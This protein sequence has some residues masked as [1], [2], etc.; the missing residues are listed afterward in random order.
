MRVGYVQFA[1]VF[2]QKEANLKRVAAFLDSAKV[3]LIVLPE[4]FATGYIFESKQEL[5]R[6]AEEET[7]A[8]FTFLRGLSLKSG[9]AIVAGIAERYGPDCFNSCF[10]FADGE[11]TAR[12][13][14]VHLFDWEKEMFTPGRSISEICDLG[15]V[16]LGFMVCFDWIFPEVARTIALKG[17]QVLCHPA[18]LVLP[19]CPQAMITRC[20]ENRMF[21]ITA[22]RV[23]TEVRVGR[24]LTFIGTSQ[25]VGP[26][27]RVLIRAGQ[28]E[29]GI[30]VIDIDPSRAKDKMV[31]PRNHVITDRKPSLYRELCREQDVR[32]D[33]DRPGEEH[34]PEVAGP[35]ANP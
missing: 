23:G 7:G 31:T 2:G 10:L 9:I 25:V 18:N 12:Y 24:E 22:N 6:L 35:Q 21:A 26:D 16:K 8:T 34:T 1:P 3:D 4:L 20:I 5:L 19:H 17:A 28:D 33:L 29:E 14:K 30:R 11:V 32:D 13:R 27:G 15:G